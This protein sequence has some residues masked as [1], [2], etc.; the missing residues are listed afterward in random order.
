M[1]W[2]TQEK[3]KLLSDF[4]KGQSKADSELFS[5]FY[6]NSL[7]AW[8]KNGERGVYMATDGKANR[9]SS[10]LFAIL[11]EQGTDICLPVSFPCYHN[12]SLHTLYKEQY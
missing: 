1:P 3:L 9:K 11:L 7:T 8:E 2:Y 10:L 12:L 6:E 4:K 5:W